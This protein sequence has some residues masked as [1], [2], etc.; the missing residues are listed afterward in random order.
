MNKL[1]LALT[2]VAALSFGSAASAAL[3]VTTQSLSIGN[4]TGF[5][6]GTVSCA[7]DVA[8]C[9]FSVNFA[10]AAPVGFALQSADITSTYTTLNQNIDF[11]S[12]LLNGFAF[13]LSPHGQT[14]GGNLLNQALLANNMLTVNGVA[15]T[16][17]G[18]DAAFSGTLSFARAVP[19]PAT[20][21][22]MLI[23]FGAAGVSLRRKRTVL[24]MQ[25]A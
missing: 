24:A 11:S 2:A 10:F 17:A 16:T 9:N 14:E 4:S 22:M 1:A 6:N 8:A 12:V 19:E 15:G 18:A 25:A 5:Y 3:P 21:A 20:W 7:A 13:N 23:G